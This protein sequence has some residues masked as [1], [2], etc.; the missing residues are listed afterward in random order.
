MTHLVRLLGVVGA[1]LGVAGMVLYS[2]SPERLW[3]VTL[4]EGLALICLIG[5]GVAHSDTVM[6]FSARRGTRLGLN[7][8]IMVVLALGILIIVNFLA[9]RHSKRWD[10][11][12]TQR[13]TLA[14]QTY[15][16]LRGLT[17]DV[18]VT[19]FT[20]SNAYR[21]LLDSYRQVSPSLSVAYIDPDRQPAV[22]R[23]YGISR[24]D[25][26]VF[27][28]GSNSTRVTSP[29]ETDMTTALIRVSR[30]TQK[31]IQFLN[32]H[33]ERDIYDEQPDGYS[34]AK[35]ALSD[36]GYDVGTLK[37]VQEPK[38]PADVSVIIIAG[39]THPVTAPEKE[40][41]ASY[42]SGG[43][44]LFL[45]V[46]PD[47][48]HNLDDLVS[49]WGVTLGAGILVD[50]QDRLPRG[51]LSA[52]MVTN[53]TQNEFLEGFNLPV[54]FPYS[55]PVLSDEQ[56]GSDWDFLP[57]ARTSARSW[58]ERDLSSVKSRVVTFH[59]GEDSRGPLP[60]AAAILAKG[61]TKD[62][63]SRP[64]LV[65][66]GNSSFG[67]NAVIN[68]PGN[69]DFFLQAIGWLAEEHELVSITPKEAAFR[70]FI[71]SPMQERLLFSVQVVLLPAMT[72][73]WGM[74]VWWRRRRL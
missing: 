12:E 39:P 28:S 20:Q 31:K 70:P 45:M 62:D 68:F 59:E 37:L 10:L 14:P 4:C 23:Q 25:T 54:L 33:G 3:L 55:R 2:M 22:A 51:D 52:L 8:A 5:F 1:L 53:F 30:D 21:D 65:I 17:R 43:G 15:E 11:S 74:A 60:L 13:Y 19:V 47:T 66:V 24:M 56:L 50:L 9:A 6:R 49:Q 34:T 41:L 38:V 58:A 73:L 32:G 29:S 44:R 40:R 42:V 16:V 26:A 71:P 67:S 46:D 35:G 61:E 57:L 64:A 69:T 72:F 7:S 63:A 48:N 27:E 36:Q 18:K